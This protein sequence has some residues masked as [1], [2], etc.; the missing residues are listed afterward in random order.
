MKLFFALVIP[1]I[2]TACGAVTT[3]APDASTDAASKEGTSSGTGTFD[4]QPFAPVDAVFKPSVATTQFSA[5]T[6]FWETVSPAVTGTAAV[7]VISSDP[8]T[9]GS[10]S[11]G[12]ASD[13]FQ[14]FMLLL[15]VDASGHA[16]APAAPGTYTIADPSSGSSLNGKVALL[17]AG[18]CGSDT[19]RIANQGTITLTALSSTQMSGSFTVDITLGDDY[20]QGSG[21]FTAAAC[22]AIDGRY[23]GAC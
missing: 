18:V 13:A 15:D 19:A 5:F 14:M 11:I 9:C 12:S 21:T 10:F 3:T 20:G 16:T 1:S 2:I 23:N 17:F 7:L 8:K 22:T 6:P 4:G